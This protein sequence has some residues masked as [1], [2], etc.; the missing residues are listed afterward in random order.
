M[1]LVVGILDY[2]AIYTRNCN[3]YSNMSCNTATNGVI[4]TPAAT[5][6]ATLLRQTFSIGLENG[7]STSTLEIRTMKQKGNFTH[8]Y[9]QLLLCDQP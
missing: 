8:H 3:T 5:Q 9:E 4:P 7:P 6:I 1:E 2:L